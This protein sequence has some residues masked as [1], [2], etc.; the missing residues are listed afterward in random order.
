MSLDLG[1]QIL[2]SRLGHETAALG[3][4]DRRGRC[5]FC[6]LRGAC[7]AIRFGPDRCRRLMVLRFLVATAAGGR[8][9]S[10]AI[11]KMLTE[12]TAYQRGLPLGA[13]SGPFGHFVVTGPR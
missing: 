9:P 7:E 5:S 12:S 11:V 8:E 3:C 1:Q 2:G 6:R 4:F 10:C 13:N